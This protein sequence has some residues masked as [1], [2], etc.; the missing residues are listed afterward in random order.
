MPR[1]RKHFQIG[2]INVV[3]IKSSPTRAA[4]SLHRR[5]LFRCRSPLYLPSRRPTGERRLR[6]SA[7][8]DRN[9][10][11]SSSHIADTAASTVDPVEDRVRAELLAEGIE[12]DQLLNP[13]RVVK[14]ERQR[15]ECREQLARLNGDVSSSTSA[16]AAKLQQKMHKLDV[17]LERE[18]RLVMQRGLKRVFLVQGVASAAAGGWLALNATF[19]LYLRALGFWMV[20]LLTIPSLRARKPRNAEKRALNAAF[21]IAPLCNLLLPAVWKDPTGLWAAQVL[22]LLACYTYYGAWGTEADAL[23]KKAAAAAAPP[24][25]GGIRLPKV[26]RWLDWGSWR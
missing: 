15:D 7:T 19:P 22:L 16:A 2:W 25:R 4:T 5:R 13:A 20:W 18:K 6:V 1:L 12:L 9:P 14:L 26:L 3:V 10:A 11:T 17:E 21:L 24:Q 23:P 8:D